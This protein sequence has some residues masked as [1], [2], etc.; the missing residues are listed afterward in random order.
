MDNKDL[1]DTDVSYHW[2]RLYKNAKTMGTP[3]RA[4]LMQ[5]VVVKKI[6]RLSGDGNGSDKTERSIIYDRKFVLNQLYQRYK[7]LFTECTI[8]E[9]LCVAG[10]AYYVE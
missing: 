8:E 4:M 10:E 2:T 7:I 9:W 3:T 1:V 6:T 5:D